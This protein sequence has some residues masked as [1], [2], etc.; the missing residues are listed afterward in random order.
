MKI[1]LLFVVVICIIFIGALIAKTLQKQ[2]DIF[3]DLLKFC[4]VLIAQIAFTKNDFNHIV[5]Q[6]KHLFC[7][8]FQTII[9]TYFIEEKH[10]INCAYLSLNDENIILNFFNQLGMLD[11]DGEQNLIKS[12]KNSINLQYEKK[13]ENNN[14]YAPI[15]KKCSVLFAILLVIVVL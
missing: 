8:E 7:S 5:L 12:V 6:N 1:I 13:M 11:C 3:Y 15:V 14:K 10:E 9:Y 4:D 2:C